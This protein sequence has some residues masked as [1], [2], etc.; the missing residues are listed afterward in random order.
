MSGIKLGVKELVVVGSEV[1]ELVRSG[2]FQDA[3][4]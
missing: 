3:L 1:E 4:Q 2:T